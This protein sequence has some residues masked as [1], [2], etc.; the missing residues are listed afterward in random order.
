MQKKWVAF[1]AASALVAS[2]DTSAPGDM[3]LVTGDT[4]SVFATQ[5]DSITPSTG[6]RLTILK[7]DAIVPV[8]ACIDEA[9][10]SIYKI[11]L[12]DG[13]SGYV[14]D[15]DYRLLDRQYSDSAWCGAKPRNSRWQLGWANCQGPDFKKIAQN[16][17]TG[18][19]PEL[20]VFKLNQ[21]F[22][23][24]V[25]KKYL[26]NAGSLGHE[27]RT[28][29]KLSD[30]LTHQYLYFFVLGDWS[31]GA[32][33][34]NVISA[35]VPQAGVRSEWLTV[36]L[37]R[38]PPEPQRSV[39]ERKSGE[40][41]GR[42]RDEEFALAAQETDGLRCDYWCEGFNGFETVHLRYWQRDGFVQIHASYESK[43]YGGLLVYWTTNVRDLS[44]WQSIEH[45]I[46]KLVADWSVLGNT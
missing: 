34:N 39:E 29:T 2:C 16:T 15:G 8:I 13:R 27:P 45:E 9:D 44:Q 43:R 32:K 42:Q 25:P 19:G 1:M 30:L 22:V 38:A 41:L 21:Q 33:P 23:L 4:V 12:P 10:Y 24:A 14:S 17:E 18:P 28:C 37:D 20:P 35:N 40:K 11:Q 31:S 36:R 3:H 5:K 7:P 46:W 6:T 26:P